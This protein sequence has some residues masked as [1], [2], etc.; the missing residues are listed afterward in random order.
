MLEDVGRERPE[1]ADDCCH[2]AIDTG[3][4]GMGNSFGHHD[5]V[6]GSKVDFVSKVGAN[7]KDEVSG[8]DAGGNFVVC[9]ARERGRRF[10]SVTENGVAE[11]NPTSDVR[12]ACPELVRAIGTYLIIA[13]RRPRATRM[14]N[15]GKPSAACATRSVENRLLLP[16]GTKSA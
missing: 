16:N 7:A 9:T 3:S 13:V 1:A 8:D 6:A 14:V 2:R 4:F 12:S 5:V 11:W 15:F 10:P